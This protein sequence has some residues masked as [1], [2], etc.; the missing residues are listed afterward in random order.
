MNQNQLDIIK[1]L[2]E[3]K[4][5]GTAIST[6]KSEHSSNYKVKSAQQKK[7]LYDMATK[8]TKLKQTIIKPTIF[9]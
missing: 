4:T 2:N 7:Q 9:F 1:F 8:P 3:K 6:S 5:K